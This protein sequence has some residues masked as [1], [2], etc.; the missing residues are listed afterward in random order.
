MNG[1][2]DA[3]AR[4]L[5]LDA[6]LSPIPTVVFD[7]QWQ[8]ELWNEAAETLFGWPATEILGTADLPLVPPDREDEGRDLRRRLEAGETID[9]FETLR[10]AR[11]GTPIDVAIYARRLADE[12]GAGFGLRYVDLRVQKRLEAENERQHVRARTIAEFFEAVTGAESEQAVFDEATERIVGA[13][14]G[15]A[16]IWRRSADGDYVDVAAWATCDPEHSKPWHDFVSNQRIRL[17]EGAVGR[18]IA[19]G[20]ATFL[21]SVSDAKQKVLVAGLLAEHRAAAAATQPRGVIVVPLTI[22]GSPVAA[23]AVHRLGE[24]REPFTE[25]DFDFVATLGQRIS[26]A[27]EAAETGRNLREAAERF[28]AL[29]AERDADAR[30]ARVL[31]EFVELASEAADERDVLVRLS[32]AARDSVE[33]TLGIYRINPDA[34]E[35]EALLIS[36]HDD[37]AVV[38][39]EMSERQPWRTDEGFLAEALRTRKAVFRPYLRPAERARY[40]DSLPARRRR[41]VAASDLR[42]IIAVPLGNRERQVGILVLARFG[43]DAKPF[44]DGDLAFAQE[45]ATRTNVALSRI[46]LEAARRR[47]AQRRAVLGEFL[48]AA[49]AAGDEREVLRDACR[50]AAEALGDACSLYRIN[51]NRA[52][53][54]LVALEGNDADRVDAFR[55]MITAHPLLKDQGSVGQA[56]AAH[57]TVMNLFLGA[58]D[59]AAYLASLPPDRRPAME[60]VDI[61]ATVT[62]PLDCD[63]EAIGA[64]VAARYGDA[65]RPFDDEDCLFAEALAGRTSIALSRL[66]LADDRERQARETRAL[67]EF[68]EV[69]TES[70]DDENDIFQRL[71]D[72]A[73][74]EMGDVCVIKLLTPDHA[75][76]EVRAAASRNPEVALLM[77]SV[78]AADPLPL[79]EAFDREVILTGK[80]MLASL[81]PADVRRRAHRGYEAIT[82]PDYVSHLV[83]PLR[84]RGGVIGDVTLLREL[85]S[86]PYDERD[87]AFLVELARRASL[88][89]ARHR[90]ELESR[91]TLARL[92]A[93]LSGSPI[94]LV[95][96]DRDF[97]IQVWNPAA[98]ALFGWHPDEVIGRET[99]FMPADLVEE[100]DRLRAAAIRGDVINDCETRRLRRDG[101]EIQVGLYAAP[102]PD[103]AGKL[104][105][106]VLGF[107]DLT[108]RK[109][110]ESDLR[111]TSDTLRAILD[112][113]PLAIITVDDQFLVSFWN[114]AAESIYGWTAAEV[115]G[116][117]PAYASVDGPATLE[118]IFDRVG[119]GETVE[120]E[121]TRKR[122]DGREIDIRLVIAPLFDEAGRFRGTVGISQDVTEQKRLEAELLQAQKMETIGRLAGGIAHDF[123]NILTAILGYTDLATRLTSDDEQARALGIVK[124]AAE[125]AAGLTQQLLAFSRRQMLQPRPTDAND[126][127]LRIEPILRRLIGEDIEL[128]TSVTPGTGSVLVDPTQLE[129]VILNLA[130]NARDAMPDGGSL[131]LRTE[132][133]NISPDDGRLGMAAGDYVA[134]D[135][136]DTGAGMDEETKA[137][138]FEPFFT[139]KGIGEGTGL[140]LS[141]TYGIVRQSGGYISV[142][143]ELG[144]GTTFKLFFPRLGSPVPTTIA[145]TPRSTEPGHARILLIE[146]DELILSLSSQVL[147][148]NGYEVQVARDPAAALALAEEQPFDL[149]ATDVVMPGMT[150]IEL[151]RRIHERQPTLPVFYMSGYAEQAAGR[152][153]PR[154]AGFLA[155]P[156]TPDDLLHAVE[157]ALA[158]HAG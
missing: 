1:K 73:A 95:L 139:T 82:A 111:R 72:A 33:G 103:A 30:R 55:E 24:D 46:A 118:P 9:G 53:L 85:P 78:A 79:G 113:S 47:D 148:R 35:L 66:A 75:Y 119:R 99:P 100:R 26:L 101:T 50:R 20:E 150:G 92:D 18:A 28:E 94:P 102:I 59:R 8:V 110:L 140:G 83:A 74:R 120:V 97:R 121:R 76:L 91:A 64:F 11:D 127:I 6:V 132:R 80:P 29:A 41:A 106:T 43:P 157:E 7:G 155:K 63:G 93:V 117:A 125:R 56:L 151:A 90:A 39:G 134:I 45:L 138:I 149:L 129:Q 136:S 158:A 133:V 17:G 19:T 3:A 65:A 77:K 32:Q 116:K 122:K 15:T 96:L 40:L 13:V 61:R 88:V 16:S 153:G 115:I 38:F 12:V 36:S 23:L 87:L 51:P 146:D 70:E 123:N 44:T 68:L 128:L 147:S 156:F 60:K 48:A 141:T 22:A 34:P 144:S 135:V 89:L 69:A 4:R 104:A 98:E 126:E 109:R 107:V 5:R 54:E 37:T 57:A 31:A 142:E 145:E 154:V 131:V 14:R 25:N 27:L 62:V 81:D 86:A 49:S 2:I 143:S 71:A 52:E 108:D 58:E 152:G 130:V 42:A 137:H 105:G 114:R 84:L 112:A 10:I 124:A 67:A 21:A